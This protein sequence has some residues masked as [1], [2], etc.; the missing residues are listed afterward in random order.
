MLVWLRP[1]ELVSATQ[2]S[3]RILMLRNVVRVTSLARPATDQQTSTVR[4]ASV[5]RV[6]TPLLRLVRVLVAFCLCR[7]QGTVRRFVICLA[8]LV[9]VVEQMGARSALRMHIWRG[10]QLAPVYATL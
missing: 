10:V 8:L 3:T 1:L 4:A 5:G 2:V 9:R 7:M 6:G